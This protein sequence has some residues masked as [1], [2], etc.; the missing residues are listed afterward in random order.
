[1]SLSHNSDPSRSTCQIWAP[2]TA[3]ALHLGTEETRVEVMR[4][5]LK[6]IT[7]RRPW[8]F[9]VVAAPGHRPSRQ[10]L[11]GR[12]RQLGQ[13]LNPAPR[14]PA[15]PTTPSTF[16][17][18]RTPRPVARCD[19]SA[20]DASA[21]AAMGWRGCIDAD[22]RAR[23]VEGVLRSRAALLGRLRPHR[24]PHSPSC[25]TASA[26]SRPAA[27]T[28]SE[29]CFH[30]RGRRLGHGGRSMLCRWAIAGRRPPHRAA[31]RPPTAALTTGSEWRKAS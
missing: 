23:P 17:K 31:L 14:A 2:R 30:S 7:I 11:Q 22:P 25:S 29:P 19:V 12:Y 20:A 9:P 4:Q 13:A 28:R 5:V 1:M 16:M 6:L 21:P 8:G 27:A 15:R 24:A 18:P 10:F 3:S 26:S